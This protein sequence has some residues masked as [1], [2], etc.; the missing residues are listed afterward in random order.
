MIHSRAK[1][2][3][4][5]MDLRKGSVL[6]TPLRY[7]TCELCQWGQ[8]TSSG[9]QE[10]RKTDL[11]LA[12]VKYTYYLSA[13]STE[14]RGMDVLEEPEDGKDTAQDA[15]ARVWIL[16]MAFRSAMSICV[17]GMEGEREHIKFHQ[18]GPFKDSVSR[19]MTD[20][21]QLHA[22]RIFIKILFYRKHGTLRG[23]A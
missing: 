23:T 13:Y 16:N 3:T 14:R 11:G 19:T 10:Q 5:A 15:F 9:S 7:E 8:A 22:L 17:A 18:N 1:N 4:A 2:G 12:R 21:V 20:V 6:Y